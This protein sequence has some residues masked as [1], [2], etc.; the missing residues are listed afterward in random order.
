MECILQAGARGV[1]REIEEAKAAASSANQLAD[2][3]ACDLA[4][5]REDL[6]KMKE[7][8]AGN[9]TQWRGLE[10]RML[11]LEG[12]LQPSEVRCGH[13][14]PACTN[15][16]GSAVSRLRSRRIPTSGR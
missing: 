1:G 9:E 16:P 10:H 4:E 3:L 15:S 13:R 2:Q 5:A 6:Q 11:G 8:V 14:S 7:L 12:H